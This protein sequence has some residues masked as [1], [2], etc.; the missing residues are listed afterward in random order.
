MGKARY[1]SCSFYINR[2]IAVSPGGL[3]KP[4][5]EN[6]KEIKLP[7]LVAILKCHNASQ[8]Q[9]ELSKNADIKTKDPGL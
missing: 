5:I 6:T 4:A 8:E 9:E 2:L 3:D 1:E 7:A